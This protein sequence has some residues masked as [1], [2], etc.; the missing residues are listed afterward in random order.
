MFEVR[1]SVNNPILRG[2]L[3]RALSRPIVLCLTLLNFWNLGNPDDDERSCPVS[4]AH[5]VVS[6]VL[7]AEF[8][9]YSV[10][11]LSFLSWVDRQYVPNR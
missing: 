3:L 4:R 7:V 6:S 8:G 5:R 11:S 1:F 9:T 2:G 10:R